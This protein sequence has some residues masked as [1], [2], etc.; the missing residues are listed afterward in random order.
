MISAGNRG[1]GQKGVIH[2][3]TSLRQSRLAM[4][5]GCHLDLGPQPDIVPVVPTKSTC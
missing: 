4:R 5:R 3:G 2:H 1:C